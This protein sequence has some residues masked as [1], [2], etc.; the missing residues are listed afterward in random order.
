MTLEEF[1]ATRGFTE[2]EL[3]KWDITTEG[4]VVFIPTLG[5]S[6]AWYRRIHRPNGQPKYR[7]EHEGVEQHLYNPLG[8]GPNS[9][10]VWIAEGEFDTLSLV[11]VGAPAVGMLGA[12]SFRREWALL[13]S[14]AR[15]ILALDP[16][17]ESS[18]QAARVQTLAQLWPE[19][20]VERFD[21]QVEGGYDDLNDWFREDRKGFTRTVLAW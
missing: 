15:I 3:A 13:F 14:H 20:Q 7:P 12:T 9:T 21:P 19:H 5:R 11:T 1:S 10:E 8:L 6:R 16:D 4:E 18:E 2:D 17:T